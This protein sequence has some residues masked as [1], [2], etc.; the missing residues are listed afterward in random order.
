LE[1]PLGQEQAH[2]ANMDMV[3]EAIA[4]RA[5]SVSKQNEVKI[6]FNDMAALHYGMSFWDN[7]K[8]D[9]ITVVVGRYQ[10]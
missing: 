2:P 1:V 8:Q 5:Y 6:P 9:D 10:G 4:R 3:A 7:G